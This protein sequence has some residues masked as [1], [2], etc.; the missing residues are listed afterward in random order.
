MNFSEAKGGETSASTC[1][2]NA[3]KKYKILT[4]FCTHSSYIA[5]GTVE[6]QPRVRSHALRERY[7]ENYYQTQIYTNNKNIH[8]IRGHTRTFTE[9]G[10]VCSRF[11][12]LPRDL[13]WSFT[14]WYPILRPERCRDFAHF[15][16]FR[17][18]RNDDVF[19][20][21]TGEQ[22]LFVAQHSLFFF[23]AI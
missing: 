12:H 14:V 10:E 23:C 8:P 7:I 20:L 5:A 16:A 18:P 15:I 17:S 1:D 19:S 9:C 22:K 4:N 11:W 3:V 2:S 21:A 6:W 13:G